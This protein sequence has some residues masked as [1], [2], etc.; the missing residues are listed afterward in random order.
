MDSRCM[1]P[2]ALSERMVVRRKLPLRWRR[3]M[4]ALRES[5]TGCAV[6][7]QMTTMAGEIA[8][9]AWGLR[10]HARTFWSS[11]LRMMLAPEAMV[12]LPWWRALSWRY[13]LSRDWAFASSTVAF[14]FGSGGGAGWPFCG[15]GGASQWIVG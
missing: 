3:C 10:T 12:A 1:G 11:W 4:S 6:R 8:V 2:M 13:Q 9:T 5:W 7:L 15:A 14:G